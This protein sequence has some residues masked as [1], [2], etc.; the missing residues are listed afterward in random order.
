MA[1]DPSREGQLTEQSLGFGY[2]WVT[3][4]VQVRKW[5]TVSIGVVAA[6]L[7]IYGAYGFA[8]WFFGSGVKERAQMAQQTLPLIDYAYFRE[9]HAPSA[10]RIDA[11]IVLVSGDKTYDIT[12]RVQNPN[13]EW[14][15]MLEYGFGT[16]PTRRTVLL[17]GEIRQLSVLGIKSDSRPAPSK[18]VVESLVWKRVNLHETRPDYSTWAN[19]RLG[20]T[21]EDAKFTTPQA[22][23]AAPVWRAD[24]TAVNGTAFGYYSPRFIVTLLSGSRVVGVNEVAVSELRPGDRRE[25]SVIW[26]SEMSTVTKIDVK[27]VVNIFDTQSYI[28]AGR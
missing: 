14:Y 2:W 3:H 28:P 15:G 11:P 23:D 22:G 21:V 19:S 7:V 10:L 13:M 8:D 9:Q 24:F 27:P 1:F 20:I 18:V 25:V 16:G 12:S 4:K 26:Y 17:P 5:F 6:P